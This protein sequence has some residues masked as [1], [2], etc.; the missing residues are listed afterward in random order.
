MPYPEDEPK[1]PLPK[2][3]LKAQRSEAV[4]R[5]KVRADNRMLQRFGEI[6]GGGVHGKK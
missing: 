2:K 1:K 6:M 4:P 5:R 3:V